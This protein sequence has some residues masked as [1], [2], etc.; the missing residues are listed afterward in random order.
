MFTQHV[1]GLD[2][3]RVQVRPI[4]PLVD[5][6]NGEAIGSTQLV[7]QG[8]DIAAIH[9]GSLDPWLSSPLCPVH[10]ALEKKHPGT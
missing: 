3:V 2:H 8:G 5:I 9:V 4:E 10:V 7:Y 6:V 1:G